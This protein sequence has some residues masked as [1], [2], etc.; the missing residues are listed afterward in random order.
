VSAL[1]TIAE[2]ARQIERRALSPVELIGECSKRIQRLEPVLHA[3][4]TP[5][6][7]AAAEQARVAEGEITRGGY[8]GPLHGIPIGLK[9]IYETAGIP[10]TAHSRQLIGNVPATDAT[11]VEKLAAAG[12]ILM[13]KLATH[14]FAMGGPSFDLPWPPARNPWNPSYFTGGS[15]S[16]TAA[17]VAA[18]LVLGGT[19]TDTGGSIRTPS[20]YCGL[21][22]I[23]PTYGRVSKAGILPLAF[24]LDHAGP[25]AWTA[26]DCALLLQAMAG[27]D[28]RD[29]SSADRLV[30]DFCGE[31]ERGVRGVRIGVVRHFFEHDNPVQPQTHS[32]LEA[33]IGEL[34][35]SGA[36]I[37]DVTLPALVEWSACGTIVNLGE[38]FTV[39]RELLR[40]RFHDYGERLRDRLLLG[41]TISAADFVAATRRR[42]ELCNELAIAMREVDIL[43][44]AT[45]GGEAPLIENVP[46]W[47]GLDKPNFLMPFNLSGLPAMSIC[48]GFGA[49]GMPLAMQLVAKPFAEPTIFRVAHA[50]E[51][52]STWRSHRPALASVVA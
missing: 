52:L 28:V 45:T 34:R 23:K 17:A 3:F 9:D 49:N 18:G 43:L 10:T 29:P 35:A 37:R 50:Y 15:S 51:K 48:I 14:E 4:I 11:T 12:T 27:Y 39:H 5:T 19:G 13:G 26:E 32:A 38:S 6:L 40:T 22:G 24:S 36:E 33:A 47:G 2:A 1:P 8:R 41:A 25:M 31:L 30:P 16:G 7:D 44:T 21:A 46:K 20:A 42:R